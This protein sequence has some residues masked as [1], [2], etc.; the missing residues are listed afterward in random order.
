MHEI[1]REKKKKVVN[2][3]LPDS[4]AERMKKL[5]GKNSLSESAILRM[6]VE[7]G[8]PAVEAMFAEGHA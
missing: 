2:V 6:A 8:L 7:R 4:L 1:P 3:R 5:Q